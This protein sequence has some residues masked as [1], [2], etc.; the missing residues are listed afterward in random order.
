MHVI[1]LREPWERESLDEGQLRLTRRFHRP[2]GLDSESRVWLAVD[3]AAGQAQV[4]LNDRGLG[5]IASYPARLEVTQF[6][7]P[8]NLLAITLRAPSPDIDEI[9]GAVR[10]EID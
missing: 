7:L 8:L 1:R 2:T 5:E 9:L 6:L 10:L 3:H 4:T